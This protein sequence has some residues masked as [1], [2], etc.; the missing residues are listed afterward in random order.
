MSDFLP[1]LFYGAL[2][3]GVLVLVHELGHFLVAKWLGVRVLQFSIG[4]G[5]RVVG[6]RRGGTD[7]R[8]SALPLGGY[9]RM[10]GDTPEAEERTG[11]SDEFLSKPW[12]ARALITAAGPL[13][14][15]FFALL[16]NIGIF[17][18][19][20]EGRDYTT[21]I[22][23]V[24]AG[25]MAERIGL[26]SGDH[27][28]SYAGMPARTVS[29]LSSAMDRAT[30]DKQ[31]KP[32]PLHV[33]RNGSEAVLL[34]DPREI[35]QF[36]EGVDW[37]MGTTIGQVLIG[38]PAYEKG[39]KEG[40]EILRIDGNR[41]SIWSQLSA[42]LRSK[43]DTERTLTVRRGER[44]F[45][46]RLRTSPEGTIGISAPETLTF[47]QT[48][49]PLEAV[50]MGASQTAWVTGQIYA[51]LWSFVSDPVRLHNTVAGPIAIAQVARQQ[52]AGGIQ[53]LVTFAAFISLALMVMNL[54]PI[55]I[56]DGG[57]ILFAVIEGIRKRPLSLKTQLAF[58]R[59][60]LFVLIGLVVFA[61]S[62]DIS[63]V[64]KRQRAEADIDRRLRTTTPGDTAASTPGP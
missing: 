47:H 57:H 14:N 21:R 53:Q 29:E 22:S 16:L 32:L 3:L 41:V 2:I 51:G 8:I 61:F 52:A 7:Y 36:A 38:Y 59:V 44:V 30:L 46:V 25:S 64:G 42:E 60:G 56:L 43:P 11:A 55:P 23:N 48:F 4:M 50:Q 45:D 37:D 39:L 34:L 49:P 18:G 13:A 17:L 31:S 26:Q 9:V 33:E 6:F 10:A 58:Q 62:N 24:K 35:P 28:V 63:R 1:V 15:L 40:D 19:G 12:W 20:V 5:P 27:I 54:L